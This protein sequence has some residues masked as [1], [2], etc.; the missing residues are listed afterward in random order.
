MRCLGLIMQVMACMSGGLLPPWGGG[1]EYCRMGSGVHAALQRLTELER[2]T[3]RVAVVAAAG[4]QRVKPLPLRLWV[5]PGVALPGLCDEL[6]CGLDLVGRTPP[7]GQ[8][9]AGA[10][11]VL[12][13]DALRAQFL[14]EPA[15]S[16]RPPSP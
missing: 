10:S 2:A 12:V 9:L 11:D 13:R 5:E 16:P 1:S 3:N 14:L 7:L 6:G 8:Q 15:P 4:E